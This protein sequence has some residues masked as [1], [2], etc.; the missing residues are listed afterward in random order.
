MESEKY[1]FIRPYMSDGDRRLTVGV[2]QLHPNNGAFRPVRSSD[3]DGRTQF[4]AARQHTHRG[5]RPL[6]H[7][8]HGQG[9]LRHTAQ[10]DPKEH[11]QTL[12]P[13]QADDRE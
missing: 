2:G 1:Q 12:G 6:T 9:I 4:G 10:D 11:R 7:F 3:E 5:V 8:E 13:D